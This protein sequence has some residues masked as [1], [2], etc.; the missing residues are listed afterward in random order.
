GGGL[1]AVYRSSNEPIV[2]GFDWAIGAEGDLQHD[3]RLNFAHSGDGVPE[4]TPFIDQK[5]K[6]L[7]GAVF[8]QV[9][10][11][12]VERVT[13]LGGLRY[14]VT[15]FEAEDRLLDDGDDSGDRT[16][17]AFSPSI[18]VSV[19]VAE[20]L[21]VYGNVA[22]SFETPTATELANQPG[23]VGGFNQE[24]EPQRTLSFE[25]G[26]KGL[27]PGIASYQLSAFRANIDDALI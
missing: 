11:V 5:E 24:L 22:S 13:L 19:E 27:F 10:A 21:T 25:G 23:G 20:P 3:D 16:M 1:G 7:G 26:V 9:T 6:V 18:G 14:D 2:R 12:P 4:T 8:T 15:R 17:N